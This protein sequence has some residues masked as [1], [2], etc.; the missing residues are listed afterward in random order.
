MKEI[1]KESGLTSANK[2]VPTLEPLNF[3]ELT[4]VLG[5]ASDNNGDI[6]IKGNGNT[7]SAIICFCK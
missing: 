1:T 6:P 4:E 5:G 7:G 2:H 3:A